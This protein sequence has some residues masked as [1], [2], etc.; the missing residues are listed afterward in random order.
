MSRLRVVPLVALLF[1]FTTAFVILPRV[2]GA[3]VPLPNT[4]TVDIVVVGGSSNAPI[5]VGGSCY[6]QTPGFRVIARNINNVPIPGASVTLDFSATPIR[7]YAS[8][9]DGSTV[10]CAAKM[11]SRLTDATGLATFYPVFGGY[12]NN[13]AVEVSADGVVLA[14]IPARSTDTDAVGATTGLSDFTTFAA[15]FALQQPDA[16]M[17]FDDCPHGASIPGLTDFAIFSTQFQL[18]MTGAYCP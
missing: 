11:L 1:A 6:T 12:V 17:N 7:L 14:L 2:A 18:A 8:Q 15:S 10:N 4:S 5:T 9:F 3:D 16:R 13:N